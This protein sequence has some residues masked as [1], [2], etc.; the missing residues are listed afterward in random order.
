LNKWLF[1]ATASA[2]LLG[3]S[4]GLTSAPA[5]AQQ[6]ST[7]GAHSYT[8]SPEQSQLYVQVYHARDTIASGF[9]HDHVVR[10]GTLQ[11]KVSFDPDNPR[12]CSLS[13]SVPVRDLVVD[14]PE[15][16]RA[17]GYEDMLDDRDRNKVRANMLAE[18]QLDAAT[19]PTIDFR[20]ADCR[21][22]EGKDEVYQVRLTV[23]VRG[24]QKTRPV[25]VHI[26]TEGDSLRARN[27]FNMKHSDFG[28][29]PYSALMG[30][31]GNAQ[32]IRFVTR[33]RAD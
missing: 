11:G 13:L 17:V 32:P 16:R 14:E 22:V 31:V 7:N 29:E 33:L 8:I 20:A 21:P 30:A 6:N 10:A 2:V 25:I 4:L 26:E 23:T 9:A 3:A 19:Y 15:L 5:V 12:A 1:A 27:A 28:M 18:G 24:K